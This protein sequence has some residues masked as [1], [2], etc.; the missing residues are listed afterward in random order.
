VPAIYHFLFLPCAFA[1]VVFTTARIQLRRKYFACFALHYFLI[2]FW[3][4]H[5]SNVRRNS[6]SLK[7]QPLSL[8]A[9]HER[10]TNDYKRPG[11]MG[12]ISKDLQ[13]MR[14]AIKTHRNVVLDSYKT[15]CWRTTVL[16]A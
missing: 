14:N 8:A 13:K 4:L 3:C 16:C 15:F 10:R 6:F 1:S 12:V 5:S 9:K 2:R 7:I 11:R